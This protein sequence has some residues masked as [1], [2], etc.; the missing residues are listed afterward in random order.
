MAGV[1]L[2]VAALAGKLRTLAKVSTGRSASELGIA[3]WQERNAR[4]ELQGWSPESLAE[5]I[6]AVAEADEEVKGLSRDPV[7]AAERAVLRVAAARR[8]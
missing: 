8:R 6:L 3:P 5:A 2:I 7:F 4:S 1:A